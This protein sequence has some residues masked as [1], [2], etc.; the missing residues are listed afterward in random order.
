MKGSVT[1]ISSQGIQN[2]Y[3]KCKAWFEM[4][5]KYSIFVCFKSNFNEVTCNTWWIHF[6]ST[7]HVSNTMHGFLTTQTII[8]PYEHFIYMGNWVKGPVEV[9]RTFILFLATWY[10]LDFHKTLYVRSISQNLVSLSRLDNDGY[11]FKFRNGCF[12]LFQY[13]HFIGYGILYDGLYKLKLD[14]NFTETLLNL[15]YDVGTKRSLTIENS[16]SLWPKRLGHIY[17][18]RL[19]KPI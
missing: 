9:I 12:S 10:Y 11:S 15:H 2:D 17:R 16:S 14:N 3:Y 4:K 1:S 5:C 18:E 8:N 6:G 7:V 13:A 19:E